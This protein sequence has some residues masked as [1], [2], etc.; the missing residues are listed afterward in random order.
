MTENNA[1]LNYDILDK[2]LDG[3][4]GEAWHVKMSRDVV[5]EHRLK[6]GE[7]RCN[8]EYFAVS[9]LEED[10][11]PEMYVFPVDEDGE[12]ISWSEI[13]VSRKNETDH[14]EVLDDFA[15]KASNGRIRG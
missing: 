5:V 15:E 4:E 7:I 9:R 2:D 3:F 1:T 11:Y 6:K 13:E 10:G 12:V 8:T 14:R